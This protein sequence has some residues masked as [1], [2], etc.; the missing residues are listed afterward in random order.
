[1][2]AAKKDLQDNDSILFHDLAKEIEKNI[3][4]VDLQSKVLDYQA[5]RSTKREVVTAA[6]TLFDK[7]EIVLS[8][9]ELKNISTDGLSF[10]VLPF[11]IKPNDQVFV[12]FG[13]I[14]SLG[15]ILCTVQWTGHIS[16]LRKDH[17]MIGLKFTNLSPI[18]QKL[19]NEFLQKLKLKSKNEPI[20][21]D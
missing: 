16:S 3:E 4:P 8:K 9:A 11:D 18:K 14:S 17:K 1:M 6:A 19:L 10:E 13:S 15:M 21:V 12:H 7:N 2:G 5:K 20:Y